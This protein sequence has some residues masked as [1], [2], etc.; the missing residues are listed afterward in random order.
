MPADYMDL[1]KRDNKFEIDKNDHRKVLRYLFALK[2]T[3]WL[4]DEEIESIL[5]RNKLARP[6]RIPGR[7]KV[8]LCSGVLAKMAISLNKAGVLSDAEFQEVW[9]NRRNVYDY[10]KMPDRKS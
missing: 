8:H 3:G 10:H 5:E 6:W 4:F 7:Y 9:H 1:L 2:Y